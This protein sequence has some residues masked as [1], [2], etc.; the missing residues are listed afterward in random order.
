MYPLSL[1][2]SVTLALFFQSCRHRNPLRFVLNAQPVFC[3]VS[4]DIYFH[5]SISIEKGVSNLKNIHI[6]RLET[7][8]N[9]CLKITVARRIWVLE[10]Y[11][12]PIFS[13]DTYSAD[14][15]LAKS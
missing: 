14:Q 10:D 7:F 1:N 6:E 4:M 2:S 15:L 11:E 9:H 13:S 3:S 5:L 8:Y 12:I